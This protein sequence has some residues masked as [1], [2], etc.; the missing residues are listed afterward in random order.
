[1][2]YGARSP[3]TPGAGT[4]IAGES[5]RAWL[6]LFYDLVFVAAILI[7]SSAFSHAER[8]RRGPLVR[9]RR[10]SR[11]GGSGSRRRMHANRFPADDVVYR[12]LTL[13]QMFLV[14]LV[15]IGAERRRARAPRVRLG[16]LR[17]AHA[18]RGRDLRRAPGA[19]RRSRSFARDRA[20]EYTRRRG[21]SSRG[22]RCCPTVPR[23]VLWVIGLGGD[24]RAGDRALHD[25]AAA[26]GAPP[27][28]AARR[29]DDHHVR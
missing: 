3:P 26:G 20:L 8:R 25:R 19:A 17:P 13:T 15:A 14:A 7:L 1:M 22:R 12:L 24:D 4:G 21:R 9:A 6:D 27:D 5:E 29:A 28:R 10:S 11:S 18:D 16:L 2:P 23:I